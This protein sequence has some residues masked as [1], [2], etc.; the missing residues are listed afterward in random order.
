MEL[1]ERIITN[2][3]RLLKPLAHEFC[4]MLNYVSQAVQ[5]SS[6][7]ASFHDWGWKKP[8]TQA[9]ILQ[10]PSK[11]LNLLHRESG[12]SILDRSIIEM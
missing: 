8:S 4:H 5:N 6:H 11:S 9:N 12:E 1:A 10:A 2:E 3:G 7:G